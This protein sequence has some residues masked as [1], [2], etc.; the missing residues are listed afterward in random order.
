MKKKC[1]ILISCQRHS[2]LH[3]VSGLKISFKNAV[4]YDSLLFYPSLPQ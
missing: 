4:L 3:V 1:V 2:R